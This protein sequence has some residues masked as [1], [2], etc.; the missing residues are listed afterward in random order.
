MKHEEIRAK[1]RERLQAGILL[2][3][4]PPVT[5]LEP[6]SAA[7][8]GDVIQVGLAK[9]LCSACDMDR[10]YITYKYPDRE[11]RFHHECQRIWDE[12]R[13]KGT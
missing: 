2:R 9:G 13:Q 8:V 1:I 11:V 12:E 3:T 6:G 5:R 4:Q 10:P 7:S